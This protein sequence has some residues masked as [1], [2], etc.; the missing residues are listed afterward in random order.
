MDNKIKISIIVPVYNSE[1]TISR[2]IESIINQTYKNLELIIINDG[3]TDNSREICSQYASQYEQIRYIE[4]ENKGVSHARNI[5]IKNA[6]G[7]YIMF[8]DSDDEFYEN[9]VEEMLCKMEKK[10][11]FELLVFAYERIHINTNKIKIMRTNDILLSEGKD[12]NIFIETLQTN[13]LFNQIWNKVF[14][15]EV[16][17]S[18][19]ILFDETIS[20]GE[21]YKF[22][23]QYIDVINDAAYVDKV[24]YKYYSGNEGLSLK[25]GPEKIYTKLDNLESQRKLYVKMNYDTTYI[26]NNYVYTCL[27]GLTA[28]RD[29]TD[30][31]KTKEY[32][33]NYIDN[34]EIRNE[35]SSIKKRSKNLIIKI[36]IEILL[37]KRVFLLNFFAKM[38]RIAR[39]IY[40]KIRLG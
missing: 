5:G 28:M 16:L 13:C 30:S 6:I 38:L 1:K 33:Q 15:K 39:V 23:I 7:K 40:R 22:N 17:I 9:A 8:I 10:S 3:S 24:L 18:N 26:D 31:K 19:H 2:T 27:S 14:I 21:D 25:T 20:S 35:L 29:K 36:C 12:K 34:E 32:I 4:V 11:N 37:I